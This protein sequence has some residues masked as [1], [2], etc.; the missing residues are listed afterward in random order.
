MRL[1]LALGLAMA[2]CASA[3]AATVHRS[4]PRHHP[5]FR[6]AYGMVPPRFVVRPDPGFDQ[7]FPPVI[8]DQTPSYDDPSKF[9]GG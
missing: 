6:R 4:H 1:I 9:G 8:H 3:G 2:L 5:S 7:R